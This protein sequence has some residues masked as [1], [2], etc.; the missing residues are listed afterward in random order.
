MNSYY[1]LEKIYKNYL[2]QVL[3]FDEFKSVKSADG[4]MS[5]HLCNGKNG[6]I[7]DIVEDRR[8][9]SLIK[10]FSRYSH[11]ARANVKVI[12][13]DMYSP[14]VS[15]IKKMFPN[16]SIV[17]DKFH[18]IQLISRSLNKTRIKLMKYDKNNY[19]KLK[20]YWKLLLKSRNDIDYSRWKRFTCFSHLTTESDILNYLLNLS[21]ELK[22]TYS[23][24]QNLLDAFQNDDFDLFY[25]TINQ[26]HTNVSDYMLTS[27]KTLKE[28][29]PYIKFHFNNGFIEG[30]NNFIK[31]IKRIAFGFKSF[32]RFKARIMI[33]K[34]LFFI[35][36]EVAI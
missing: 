20:R 19:T 11:K 1:D 31:V 4:A 9:D 10:Y 15:L 5:F 8:L 25:N 12:T 28:F 7:I 22:N 14:Y 18:L 30:N 27:I 24:Y 21:D 6:K 23:V 13:I 35:K 29:S 2:P 3:S 16:A 34:G 36:K 17:I 26:K 33:C 32:R